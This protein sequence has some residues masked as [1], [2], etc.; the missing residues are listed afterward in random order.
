MVLKK[1]IA[2]YYSR[3]YLIQGSLYSVVYL[4]PASVFANQFGE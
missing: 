3:E 1:A 2:V 4:A